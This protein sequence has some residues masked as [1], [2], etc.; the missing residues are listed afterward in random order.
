MGHKNT[1][2]PSEAVYGFASW[3]ITRKEITIMSEI[4]DYAQIADLV[5]QFCDANKL[6]DVSCQWPNNLVHPSGEIAVPG[7]GNNA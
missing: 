4:H 3:L 2:N 6:P 1:L 5:K 7:I